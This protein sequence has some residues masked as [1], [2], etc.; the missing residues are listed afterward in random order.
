MQNSTLP[1]AVSPLSGLSHAKAGVLA[2]LFACLITLFHRLPT[3]TDMLR[4]TRI[5]A[6]HGLAIAL[7]F[8]L[9]IFL[10][11]LLTAP[12]PPT[13]AEVASSSK[14]ASFNGMFQKDLPGSDFLHWGEGTIS[15]SAQQISFMGSLAPGPDYKLYLTPE[16]VLTEQAFLAVKANSA[17]VGD[18]RTF[19]NFILAVPPGI[20][21]ESY[22]A[23]IIWCESFGEFITAASYR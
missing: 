6:T 15:L 4:L 21:L 9:G 11:P 1:F 16:L 23:V 12:P 18:V 20:D 3:G 2:S 14:L 5:L 22:K 8:A 7:G 19:D 10:L 17:R 13:D